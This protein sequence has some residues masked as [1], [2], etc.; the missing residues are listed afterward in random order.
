MQHKAQSVR[1]QVPYIYDYYNVS[2]FTPN[3]NS[4]VTDVLARMVNCLVK[5]LNDALQLPR[6]IVIIPD[7]DILKFVICKSE[8]H[9]SMLVTT[10][11]TWVINQ[12]IRAVNAKKDNLKCRKPGSIVYNEPKLI[13]ISMIDC[14]GF[15]AE[16][17][18]LRDLFNKCLADILSDKEFHY[19]MDMNAAMMDLG[20]LDRWGDLNTYGK[21]QF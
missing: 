5:A 15:R 16:D 12:M 8:D 19:L 18:S 11:I 4:L 10:T 2:C 17:L 3:P 7:S 13:W 20:N 6:L 9:T 21:Q 1:Q 14:V